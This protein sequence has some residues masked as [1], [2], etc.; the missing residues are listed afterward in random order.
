MITFS[1]SLIPAPFLAWVTRG[2][3]VTSLCIV[4]H[5]APGP[6]VGCTR[7]RRAPLRHGQDPG[8]TPAAAAGPAIDATETGPRS[9]SFH[10]ATVL[11]SCRYAIAP[12]IDGSQNEIPR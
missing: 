6:I 1:T 2:K 5:W 8:R 7:T 9:S 12:G 10:R 11:R 3:G 4:Y